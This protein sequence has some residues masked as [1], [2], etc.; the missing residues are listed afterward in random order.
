MG[1]PTEPVTLSAE[2]VASLDRKL[3]DLRHDINN[4]LS[5]MMA[6]LELARY[7]PETSERMMTS[8]AEQPPK[9]TESLK[10]FSGELE[11]VLGI[12]NQ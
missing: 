9:I 2:Q 1:L 8:L 6:A 10:K 12:T 5:L 3:S 4:H 7:R 11:A